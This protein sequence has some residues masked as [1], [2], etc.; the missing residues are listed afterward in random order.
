M[1]FLNAKLQKK[2]KRKANLTHLEKACT[3]FLKKMKFDRMTF[4]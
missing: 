2:K 4:C 1:I 3:P